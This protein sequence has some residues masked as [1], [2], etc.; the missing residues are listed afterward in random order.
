M[1]IEQTVKEY[2]DAKFEDTGIKAFLEYPTNAPDKFVTIQVI[3]RGRESLISATTLELRSY[4]SS[5]YDSA[6]LDE[7]VRGYMD[8]M[9]AET[10]IS[11]EL[12][13]GNDDF[14][15]TFKKYRYRSYFNFYI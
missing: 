15:T 2:L 3:D 13:G 14:D 9:N 1:L 6:V 5:H 12:G 8:D 7:T 4:A 10:D 11:V